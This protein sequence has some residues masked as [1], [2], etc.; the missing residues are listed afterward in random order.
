M[1]NLIFQ[2]IE[3][4]NVSLYHNFD[5]YGI[6]I[7]TVITLVLRFMMVFLNNKKD[8]P[9]KIQALLWGSSIAF[10]ALIFFFLQQIFDFLSYLTASEFIDL[11]L[12]SFSFSYDILLVIALWLIIG[13]I[14]FALGF[15]FLKINQSLVMFAVIAPL[16]EEFFY[17]YLLLG[18]FLS[19]GFTLATT[20]FLSTILYSFA[21]YHTLQNIMEGYVWAFY[22]PLLGF[23]LAWCFAALQYGLIFAIFMHALANAVIELLPIGQQ[24]K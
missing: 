5:I 16:V 21:I 17:R 10:I 2:G 14:L 1:L 12:V 4:L 11:N 19:L 23:G 18:I 8:T 6:L 22:I 3:N 15:L 20:V 24:K 9:I 7:L 13:L